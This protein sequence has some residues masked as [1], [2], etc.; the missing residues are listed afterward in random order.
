MLRES[1]T[2]RTSLGCNKITATGTIE[3]VNKFWRARATGSRHEVEVPVKDTNI[4]VTLVMSVRYEDQSESLCSGV[5][6]DSDL[7]FCY[8]DSKE[9]MQVV[10]L[11]SSSGES[12]GWLDLRV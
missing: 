8:A 4:E 9:I 1:G 10:Q 3:W 11:F 6:P 12:Q 7:F 5:F 2:K